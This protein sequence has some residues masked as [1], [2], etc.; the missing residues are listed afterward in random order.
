LPAY[1]SN[2]IGPT[3]DGTFITAT[4]YTLLGQGKFVKKPFI[5]GDCKDE[6]TQFA[7]GYTTP[8]SFA[9]GVR[10]SGLYTRSN[11]TVQELLQLYP[12]VPADGS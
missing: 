10:G 11:D 5:E 4:P 2:L 9:A 8:A 12:D 3:I 7:T 1:F 6:G